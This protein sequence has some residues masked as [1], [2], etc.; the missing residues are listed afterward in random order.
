MASTV[1]PAD[2]I[3]IKVIDYLIDHFEGVVIGNEVMYGSNRK[4]V[5]LLALYKGE[6]YAI[7]IKSRKDNL[8][9][10]PEQLAEY[11]K[12]FDH[13]IIF[14][15]FDHLYKIK[16]M[17]KPNVSVFEFT[18][19]AEIYGDLAT[20]KNNPLKSEMLATM[21]ATYIRR[22]LK[23]SGTLDSDKT[24]KKA[25][26]NKKNKIHSLLYEYFMEKLYTPYIVFLNERW[27]RTEIDDM[28]ILSNRLNI[29]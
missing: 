20:K 26:K 17:V 1:R 21:N 10:L 28:T 14:T 27:N 4:V 5:D 18:L 6:S 3:K 2:L 19:D 25:I 15:E 9:R 16:Q 29:E 13:T 12:I 7:E 24:R 23:I 8:T 22:R 11:S